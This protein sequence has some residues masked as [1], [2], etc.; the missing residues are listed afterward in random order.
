M[1]KIMSHLRVVVAL[2]IGL[3]AMTSYPAQPTNAAFP[4]PSGLIAFQRNDDDGWQIW[5]MTPN[6]SGQVKLA[7]AGNNTDPAWSADGTRIAFV[8]DRDGNN[9]IYVMNANGSGQTRLTDSLAQDGRPAWSPDGQRIA[10]HSNGVAGLN[11]IWAMDADG[12]DAAN[13]TNNAA[14]DRDPAWSPNGSTIAFQTNRDG[15][16]EIYSMDGTGSNVVNLS[17]RHSSAEIDPNWSPDGGKLT[18]VSYRD[19][20]GEVYTMNA[21]GSAQ[22]KVTTSPFDPE[23]TLPAWSPDGT[24]LVYRLSGNDAGIHTIKPDGTA[25][26]RLTSGVLDW[27]PDWQPAALTPVCD[28]TVSTAGGQ[29]EDDEL[30]LSIGQEFGVFGTG[31]PANQMI[32]I[33]FEVL[34]TSELFTFLEPADAQGDFALVFYLGPFSEGSWRITG[35]YPVASVCS[36]WVNLEAVTG[37]P[38]TDIAGHPFEGEIAWLFQRGITSGCSATKFC[39]NASVTREQMASFLVRALDLPTTSQ[40]FF[41]D[42]ETSTHEDNINRL[43]ASGI[44]L[45]CAPQRFCPTAVVTREQM[46]TFLVRAFDLPPTNLDFFVDDETS[47]HESNINRLAASGIT[48]GCA[49]SKYCPKAVVTRGQMA[50]FLERALFSVGTT[51]STAA[52]G[53]SD[54]ARD[55]GRIQVG[56]TK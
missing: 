24:R 41:I 52:A 19:G 31:Y 25:T 6:G 8:S 23:S 13:L 43:A 18:F 20:E 1:R 33:E 7:G 34:E 12:T 27:S 30:D 50:A 53:V 46:A 9:E 40:D 4:G 16:D 36:D 5:V 38:F 35:S 3:V 45:G 26:R 39:P 14:E 44:T 21:D 51:S 54:L 55:G 48:G 29:P 32:N 28:L 17:V 22:A 11:D 15:D 37:H 47:A 2:T 10:F 56:A 42:D 49:A